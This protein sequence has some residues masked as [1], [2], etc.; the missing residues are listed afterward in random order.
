[1]VQR[2][3][4]GPQCSGCANKCDHSAVPKLDCK[5]SLCHAC[6][7]RLQKTSETIGKK[8]PCSFWAK[9]I[10]NK[11]DACTFGHP[12][13][14]LQCPQCQ[15]ITTLKNGGSSAPPAS[16]APQCSICAFD[17]DHSARVP[18]LLDCKH[19]LC[20]TC[21]CRL[22]TT[23]GNSNKPPCKFWAKGV[24]NK[25]DT[26]SFAHPTSQVLCPKCRT[27]TTL[28][29]GNPSALSPNFEVVSF[30]PETSRPS[31]CPRQTAPI[32]KAGGHGNAPDKER[33]TDKKVFSNS[34]KATQ[35][36]VLRFKNSKATEL[37][38]STRLNLADGRE[39]RYS[40]PNPRSTIVEF[41]QPGQKNGNAAECTTWKETGTCPWKQ[42][43]YQHINYVKV[44]H[45]PT[46]HINK[47]EVFSTTA[48]F[49]PYDPNEMRAVNNGVA[50]PLFV[51]FTPD[52]RPCNP[53]PLLLPSAPG[54]SKYKLQGSVLIFFFEYAHSTGKH[55]E[56]IVVYRFDRRSGAGGEFVFDGTFHLKDNYINC[57]AA[58]KR[59]LLISYWPYDLEAVKQVKDSIER[60]TANQKLIDAQQAELNR[61]R[62]VVTNLTT[63]VSAYE[64]AEVERKRQM[65]ELRRREAEQR[66]MAAA[67]ARRA[68]QIQEAYY[69]S[70]RA[71]D[72]IHL[73]I[74][75]DGKYT[76]LLD[77]HEG[78]FDL[79]ICGDSMYIEFPE[80][81]QHHFEINRK[82][83]LLEG[84][85]VVP[86]GKLC[87][88]F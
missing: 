68:A 20:H 71:R 80:G 19:T 32:Q 16:K 67:N 6:V 8:T 9:G 44:P 55:F 21:I 26:C 17:Y 83:G 35:D 58:T 34:K 50:D 18:R 62:G 31:E 87:P 4:T 28:A 82:A 81:H 27:A 73:Y 48:G 75:A 76:Q 13:T 77:Y 88:Y 40:R 11:G 36:D 61:L 37:H 14:Q 24:C 39:L 53:M 84:L 63:R 5:H 86:E 85:P 56:K 74:F 72:P 15:R 78:A 69:A 23:S 38:Y 66:E 1:M 10:C 79:Q 52:G 2:P 59:Y 41:W 30:L 43:K 45:A 70:L 7:G 22:Q 46:M 64:Q 47:P 3:I 60:D 42:C 51:T 57:A 65:E 25:G 54:A 33:H 12:V 29:N 49:V